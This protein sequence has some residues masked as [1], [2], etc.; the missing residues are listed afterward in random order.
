MKQ[1]PPP[2]WLDRFLEW[3]VSEDLIEEI[4]GDLHEAYHVR[5]EKW[6]RARATRHFA[7]DVFRFFKPYAFEKYSDAKQFLPLFDNYLKVAFRNILHRKQF[8]AINLTGLSFGISAVMLI[9]LF[10]Q[11]EWTYDQSVPGHD[12]VYRLMNHYRDQVYCPM[13]FQDY[14]QSEENKQLRLIQ[15]V[16]AYKEVEVACHF[17]PSQSAIGGGDQY[18]VEVEDRK[19]V[20]ENIL[21]TNTGKAFQEIFPQTFLLGSPATAFSGFDRIVLTESSARKCFGKHWNQEEIL[22]ISLEIRGESFVLGGVI[23]DVP[24]NVH[25]I[26]DWIIHQQRIPSWGAYTYLRLAPGTAIS[27]VMERLNA[28]VD[29]VYPG[30]S[31]DVLKKG[32]LFL[33]LTDIHFSS[34][35]LYELKSAANPAY[36]YTFAFVGLILLLIIWTNY[37]HLSIAMYADRQQELGMRKVL[38]ARQQDVGLQLL[39]E[40]VLLAVCCFPVCWFLL[41]IGLPAFWKAVGIQEPS[42]GEFSWSVLATLMGLLLL[43]GCLS[44]GYPATAFG[45]RSILRLFGQESKVK[46]LPRL[47]TLRNTLLVGQFAMVIALLSMTGFITQQ[48]R[49]LSEARLGF[50]P[51]GVMYFGVD[52]AEKFYRIKAELAGIPEIQAI[53]ANGVPGT[54]MYN[55]TTYKLKGT[56]HTFSDGTQE[57]LDYGTFL[58][59][60][61]ACESCQQLEE[62]RKQL[63]L[64]NQAA[65]QKLAKIK[66]VEPEELVGETLISEPEWENEEFGYGVPYVIDGIIDDY[67]YFSFKYPHQPMLITIVNETEWAYTMLVRAKTDN[68]TKTLLDV[69]TAYESVEEVRPFDVEFLEERLKQLYETEARFG[70]LMLGLSLVAVILAMMGLAG[71]VSFVVYR[72]LKE[73]T[74]RRI[75]GAKTQDILLLF[76]KEFLLLLGLASLIA[77]PFTLYA[78]NFWLESFALHIQPQLWVVIAVSL[79]MAIPVIAMVSWWVYR[80]SQ[81]TPMEVMGAE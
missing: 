12:R 72:R 71:M 45:R 10:L 22:G 19:I 26:F 23:E 56:N 69:R 18:F 9:G 16:E 66:G 74:I 76:L 57:F 36:L 28:E 38:G 30:Y 11:H 77:A 15:H 24:S 31:E 4:Q 52:G 6:G 62:G 79:G 48:M 47:F 7:K 60:G 46:R 68:W 53:G 58:T 37:T 54:E 81:V 67:K 1:P 8:T 59:L 61:I 32:I 44:G 42:N 2:V 65:A 21:F 55:Q 13:F 14:Y 33:P 41:S 64:I 3:F 5:S 35:N 29:L 25:Y 78:A 17:V 39:L 51:E 80:V 34:G 63:F 43:T 70:R 75:N 27:A 40:A 20:A 49:Y 73:M 50:Q